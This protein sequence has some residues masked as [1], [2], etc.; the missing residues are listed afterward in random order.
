MY[1]IIYFIFIYHTDIGFPLEID[2]AGFEKLSLYMNYN[3]NTQNTNTNTNRSVTTD[4]NNQ[5]QGN[6]TIL[7]LNLLKLLINYR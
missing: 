4:R 2:T 7:I 1:Q 3:F 5:S 6:N